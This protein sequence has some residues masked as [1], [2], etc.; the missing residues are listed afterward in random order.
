[1]MDT[2]S[3]IGIDYIFGNTIGEPQPLELLLNTS[4]FAIN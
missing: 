3:G 2:L 4:Y 1:M